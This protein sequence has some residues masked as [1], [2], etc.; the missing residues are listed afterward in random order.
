MNK[1]IYKKMCV[2]VYVSIKHFKYFY[3]QNYLNEQYDM[4]EDVINATEV[5]LCVLI[6]Q[7]QIQ[8]NIDFIFYSTMLASFWGTFFKIENKIK[9][10]ELVVDKK[11]FDNNILFTDIDIS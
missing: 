11:W 6:I 10:R 4:Q 3:N 2:I 5:C 7:Q 8:N 9:Q 1:T